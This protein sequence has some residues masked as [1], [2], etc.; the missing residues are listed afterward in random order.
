MTQ[1]PSV[2]FIGLGRIGLPLAQRLAMAGARVQGWDDD[3]QAM[4]RWAGVDGKV[5]AAADIDAPRADAVVLCLPTPQPVSELLQRWA[6][7]PGL[8]APLVVDLGTTPPSLSRSFADAVRRLGAEYLDA[9]VTGG[10]A[11]AS[12]G[13][14]TVMAGGTAAAFAQAR[15]LLELI[16]DPVLHVGASGAG[17]QLKAVVQFVYLSYNAAF[18]LGMQL[19]QDAG[20]PED[21]VL[22]VLR[23][24]A[25]AHALI[26][27][28]LDALDDPASS[29][30]FLVWRALKDLGCIEDREDLAEPGRQWLET[31]EAVLAA[32]AERHGLERDILEV[33]APGL[34]ATRPAA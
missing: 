27:T 1:S 7:G 10:S 18:G 12:S 11:G 19:A 23:T 13:R 14:L 28:R 33:L 26:N 21:A 15:K 20:L 25:P 3:A 17:S 9:P 32:G 4:Q 31:L 34:R 5:A 6:R 29:A 16:G 8:Q 24:G 30:R 2:L 22:R